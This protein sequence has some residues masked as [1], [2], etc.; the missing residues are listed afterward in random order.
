[1]SRLE[2]RWALKGFRL[3]HDALVDT[4]EGWRRFASIYEADIEG[5]FANRY[6][7]DL[8]ALSD[9]AKQST[10]LWASYARE[11]TA[12]WRSSGWGR[13]LGE[14]NQLMLA[15]WLFWWRSFAT[16]YAFEVQ[17][18]HDLE[19]S[20]IN[21]NAHDIRSRAGRYTPYDLKVLG[22][23]GDIK[24]SL[25]F[26]RFGRSPGIRHDFYITRVRQQ[27]RLRVMVVLMRPTAWK[28]IN[29]DAERTTW[30]EIAKALPTVASVLHDGREIVLIE[31]G[32]WKARVRHE[33]N[34]RSR[35]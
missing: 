8:L 15:Y 9:V 31:Y 2:W 21:F 7:S 6:L 3:L 12:F 22:L 30:N 17:V 20:K 27:G 19:A 13:R 16:G 35:T 18:F 5:A 10:A 25:Y 23:Y 28:Q 11:I 33:Q 29:G 4:P 1:M 14:G 26:L 34:I 24:T 32:E